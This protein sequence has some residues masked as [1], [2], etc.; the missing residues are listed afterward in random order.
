[1][2]MMMI[3]II[4]M[5]PV[6]ITFVFTFHICC[7]SVVR[8]LY[9]RISQLFFLIAFLSPNITT[10]INIDILFSVLIPAFFV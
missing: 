9:F 10:F 1:M 4:M 3:I 2:M 6:G 8:S 7:I 5:V